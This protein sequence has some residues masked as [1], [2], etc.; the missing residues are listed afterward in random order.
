MQR[1]QQR[2]RRRDRPAKGE[3]A[4]LR[5]LCAVSHE[6]VD[7]PS[8]RTEA[9]GRWRQL[10]NVLEAST[11]SRHPRQGRCINRSTRC[12][13]PRQRSIVRR[14]PTANHGTST[15]SSLS[16]T[17]ASFARGTS[18]AA[19]CH[20]CLGDPVAPTVHGSRRRQPVRACLR[21]QPGDR[22][23]MS[24]HDPRFITIYADSRFMLYLDSESRVVRSW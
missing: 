18:S 1:Q 15:V 23:G 7:Y 16:P 12:F 6:G 5:L 8:G 3:W 4:D 24:S 17:D 19:V 2:L 21:Y 10:A 9:Q 14:A 22:C 20:D 13:H 11:R